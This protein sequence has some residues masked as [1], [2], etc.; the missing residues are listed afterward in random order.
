MEYTERQH[1]E[2]PPPADATHFARDPLAQPA[3]R[4]TDDHGP[5]ECGERAEP[6]REP[7]AIQR[8]MLVANQKSPHRRSLPANAAVVGLQQRAIDRQPDEIDHDLIL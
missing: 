5:G 3:T 1:V 8:S 4:L 7:F 6:S 2:K